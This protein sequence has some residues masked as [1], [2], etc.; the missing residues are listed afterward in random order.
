MAYINCKWS[1][2]TEAERKRYK[3]KISD[4]YPQAKVI[5]KAVCEA[6]G[7]KHI[8]HTDG[9]RSTTKMPN[10]DNCRSCGIQMIKGNSTEEEFVTL[11][12]E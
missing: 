5:G 12:E 7:A 2:C 3:E 10:N 1:Q 6:C 9:I 11:L 8:L 4:Q